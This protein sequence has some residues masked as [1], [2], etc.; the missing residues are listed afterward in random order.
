MTD[1]AARSNGSE[2][3]EIAFPEHRGREPEKSYD[4]EIRRTS[5]GIP[6]ICAASLQ[7]LAFGVGYAYA[8][9]NARSLIDAVLT[10]RGVRSFYFGPNEHGSLLPLTNL[11]SDL[12]FRL[13]FDRIRLDMKYANQEGDSASMLQAYSD[14]ARRHFAEGG[15][16]RVDDPYR[17]AIL[18]EPICR[19]DLYLL[20]A[21]RAAQTSGCAYAEAILAAAPPG[22]GVGRSNFQ[23]VTG[24]LEPPSVSASNA[25]AL[26]REHTSSGSAMLVGNPHFQWAEPHRLYEMHLTIPGELDVMGASMPPFPVINIG[27]NKDVAWTHTV[28]VSRRFAIYEL[29]LSRRSPLSYRVGG[30][31]FEMMP[32]QVRV[33]LRSDGQR[34]E[35]RRTF[36]C[37]RYG[38]PISLPDTGCTWSKRR[39]YALFDPTA[40]RVSMIGQWL[41]INKASSVADIDRALCRKRGVIWLNTIAADRSGDVYFGDLTAVPKVPIPARLF[42]RAS[43]RAR[44]VA[45]AAN[46]IVMKGARPIPWGE[47]GPGDGDPP[48]RAAERMPRTLRDDYVLNCND[49]HWLVNAQALLSRFPSYVGLESTTQGL[50]T[51]MA[52][53]ELADA[54]ARD[55]GTLSVDTL[56]E[57]IFSDRNLAA[58]LVLDDLLSFCAANASASSVRLTALQLAAA[59]VLGQWSRR[60]DLESK[61]AVLFRLFWR[62]IGT[63]DIWRH[64]FRP[65]EPLTT[66]RGLRMGDPKAA[67]TVLAALEHAAE[68]LRSHNYPLDA[69]LRDTQRIAVNGEHL[70]VP[71]GDGGAGVLNLLE[72]GELTSEGFAPTDI[73]GSSY[74]QAVSWERGRVVA[75]AILPTCQSSDPRSPHAWDQLRLFSTKGWVRLPFYE[76]DILSDPNVTYQ[77]IRHTADAAGACPMSGGST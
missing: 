77:R 54:L 17:E 50:R 52:H 7:S 58:Q 28:S 70:P 31:A 71:G 42:G 24:S 44:R 34:S 57:I 63:A 15:L 48:L 59:S 18:T 62:R 25:I 9:D 20:L 68:T 26:G 12:F 22:E 16:A 39:A 46:V 2:V 13:Y 75:D 14:G 41:Q 1:L 67:Q 27:F 10:V 5:F 74:T 55:G 53:R 61:G 40:Y 47:G 8:S 37:T 66:P 43:W 49:S 35:Y 36:Y 19:T 45:K 72:F 69:C 56:Q 21:Q 6:H 51:R 73:A 32:R 65:A 33:P 4:V 30:R 3:E 23:S 64:P 11:E 60:D 38:F 29:A 76:D